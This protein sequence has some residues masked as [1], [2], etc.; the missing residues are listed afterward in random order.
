[1]K[2]NIINWTF[3]SWDVVSMFQNQEDPNQM[4]QAMK[5]GPVIFPERLKAMD[6]V[7]LCNRVTGSMFVIHNLETRVEA[8]RQQ[9]IQHQYC[10]GMYKK[11]QR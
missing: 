9:Q 10:S 8:F 11:Q 2:G 4:C 3:A 5:L 7:N 1:M 6:S